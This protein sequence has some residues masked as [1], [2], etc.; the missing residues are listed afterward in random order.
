MHKYSIL[1]FNFLGKL[2]HLRK[3]MYYYYDQHNYTGKI[4]KVGALC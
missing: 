3:R 4:A 2:L 1:K